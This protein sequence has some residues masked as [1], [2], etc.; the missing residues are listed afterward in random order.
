MCYHIYWNLNI[1]IVQYSLILIKI[2][3]YT[4]FVLFQDST[5]DSTGRQDE[6][7]LTC[8]SSSL[9]CHV[10]PTWSA[11]GWPSSLNS[12]LRDSRGKRT[13]DYR[14]WYRCYGTSTSDGKW[15]SVPSS[16][17][18]ADSTPHQQTSRLWYSISRNLSFITDHSNIIKLLK[19]IELFQMAKIKQTNQ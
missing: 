8:T 7:T 10:K 5:E 13:S 19:Q 17:L 12:L 1:Y 11:S 3:T 14:V 2:N 18:S 16:R 9:F 6:R 4:R 15:A